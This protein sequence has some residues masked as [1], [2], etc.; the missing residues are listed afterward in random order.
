M[1]QKNNINRARGNKT[2][3][4]GIQLGG[5]LRMVVDAKEDFE[6]SEG[7]YAASGDLPP[8]IIHFEG[9]TALEVMLP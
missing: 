3:D 4:W 1:R 5:I 9:E 7:Y 8:K 2:N 6:S